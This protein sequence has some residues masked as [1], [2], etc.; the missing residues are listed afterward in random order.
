MKSCK[1]VF[2]VSLLLFVSVVLLVQAE[3]RESLTLEQ[4][5]TKIDQVG[6]S[7]RS[8]SSS[9]SQKRWTDILQE[10]DQGE[11]GQFFF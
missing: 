2:L 3:T 7:L 1:L 4:L 10:F 8:M 11:S 5:L 6:T 9:I